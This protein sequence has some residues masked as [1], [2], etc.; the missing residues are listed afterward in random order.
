VTPAYLLHTLALLAVCFVFGTGQRRSESSAA[1][2]IQTAPVTAAQTF[3]GDCLG[4]LAATL[5]LHAAVVPLLAFIVALSPHPSLTFWVFEAV[6]VAVLFLASALA[7]WSLRAES[8]R[9]SLARSF[10]ATIAVALIVAGAAALF[11]RR[12]AGLAE[13]LVAVLQNPGRS[14][15]EAVLASFRNPPTA[16]LVFAA[17][18]AAFVSFFFIHSVRR[19]LRE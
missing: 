4:V 17:L 19:A 1:D 12:P 14:S 6:V 9:W 10:R 8:W 5:A 18:Y 11:A 13:A 16:T 3:W 15:L 2:L 7:A